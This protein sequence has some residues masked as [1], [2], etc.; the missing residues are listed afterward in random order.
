MPLALELEE[1]PGAGAFPSAPAAGSVAE[2]VLRIGLTLAAAGVVLQSISD[3][4]SFTVYDLEVE[5]A[6]AESD[7]SAW[8]WASIVTTFTAAVG[9]MLLYAVRPGKSLRLVLLAVAIAFLSLDDMIQ[10]HERSAE[11]VTKLG[12][13]EEWH[14]ARL[15]WPAV[16]FPVLAATLWLLWD[17][18]S[19]MPDRYRRVLLAGAVLLVAAIALEASSPAIFWVGFE[20]GGL[21]YELEVIAEEGAELAGWVL[22]A[23]ALITFAVVLI[24]RSSALADVRDDVGENLIEH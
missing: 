9:A 7:S 11:Y 18:S 13:P 5:I 1:R 17:L 8:A 24:E 14:L 15:F 20:R 4:V 23:T 16:F 12:V 3:L 10:L 22:I 21:A 6:R 2:R 19:S